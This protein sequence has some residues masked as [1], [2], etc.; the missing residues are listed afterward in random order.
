MSISLL[1]DSPA[2]HPVM[3]AKAGIHDFSAIYPVNERFKLWGGWYNN[4]LSG[5]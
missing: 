4:T 3:P 1:I 5:L 2:A